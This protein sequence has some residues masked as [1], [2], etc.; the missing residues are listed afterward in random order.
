MRN[1]IL[2]YCQIS[3]SQLLM[4]QERLIKCCFRKTQCMR[5]DYQ[6]Q[7]VLRNQS[8]RWTNRALH[9]VQFTWNLESCTSGSKTGRSLYSKKRGKGYMLSQT[10]TAHGQMECA[11]PSSKTINRLQCQLRNRLSISD[12]HNT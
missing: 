12:Q 11:W 2:S 8:K 9:K 10:K 3:L 4:L 6:R 7:K 5:T 1:H